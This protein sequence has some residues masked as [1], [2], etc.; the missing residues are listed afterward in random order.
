MTRTGGFALLYNHLQSL[1]LEGSSA[2]SKYNVDSTAAGTP[3]TIT[4]GAGNDSFNLGFG[5]AD[6]GLLLAPLTLNGGGGTNFVRAFDNRPAAAETY[7][8][9]GTELLRSGAATISFTSMQGIELEGGSHGNLFETALHSASYALTVGGGA[10]NDTLDGPAGDAT[11]I[12]N[13]ANGGKVGHVRF[14]NMEN[15]VGGAGVDV[16]KFV[17]SGSV[18]G[19]I[20]GGSAPQNEGN[21]LDYSSLT[22]TVTVNL[23]TGKATGIGGTVSNIQNGRG[24]N[25][26]DTLTGDAQGNILI[27]GSGTDTII[28]GSGAS[29]LIGDKGA[30]HITGGSGN[31]ILIGDATTMDGMSTANQ[32]ALMAILAEW[33]SSDNY[34]TRFH[35]I[36]TGTGGG[37]NGTAKLEFGVTMLDDKSADALTAATTAD[38][39][40][41]FQGSGDTLTNFVPGEHLNNS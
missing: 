18:A 23:Q 15:L 4:T 8:F 30:D 7:D 40:W 17:G 29:L 26:G 14:F 28:G 11:W 38:F 31:D 33:Q 25:G 12:I 3:V 39:N 13:F 24:G 36:N 1:T 6:L 10:G 9:V 21:W 16:F 2:G 34:D 5:H 41:F 35:D 20:D 19:N 22:Q 37:L 32:D 27:G